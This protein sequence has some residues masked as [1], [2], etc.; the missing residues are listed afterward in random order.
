MSGAWVRSDGLV[1]RSGSRAEGA[2]EAHQPSGFA[3]SRA[4]ALCRLGLGVC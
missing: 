4:R 1:P 3:V 2:E